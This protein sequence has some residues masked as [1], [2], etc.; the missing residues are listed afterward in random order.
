[1][2]GGLAGCAG[3]APKG[4]GDGGADAPA[5]SELCAGLACV[6][7]DPAARSLALRFDGQPRA[8]LGPDAFEIG[9]EDAVLDERSYDPTYPDPATRWAGLDAME[10]VES[11]PERL[12]LGLRFSG[13]GALLATNH[14]PEVDRE[15]W[16]AAC[17]RCAHK[18]GRPVEQVERIDAPDDFPSFDGAPPLK[19]AVFR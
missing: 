19:M 1:M 4:A 10:T 7:A 15:D 9:V 18:A 3:E 8:V 12:R 13:G 2:V 5:V 16:I 14:A 6:V 17:C 11:S